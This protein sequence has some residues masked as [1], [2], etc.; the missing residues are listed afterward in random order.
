MQHVR[1]ARL[2]RAVIVVQQSVVVALEK[3][4]KLIYEC[5]LRFGQ[6]ALLAK[7]TH[8]G[9]LEDLR[10]PGVAPIAVVVFMATAQGLNL[11]EWEV[12]WFQLQ[13]ISTFPSH[14]LV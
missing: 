5:L 4:L 11:P 7:L 10:V 1:F 3:N 2:V 12:L 8:L 9:D 6:A 13:S 14:V